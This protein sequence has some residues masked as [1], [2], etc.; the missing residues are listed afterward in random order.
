MS[1]ACLRNYYV[2][3]VASIYCAICG[4][5]RNKFVRGRRVA[6]RPSI[7][8]VRAPVFISDFGLD[9]RKLLKSKQLES[10]IALPSFI[11]ML[12]T[13]VIFVPMEGLFLTMYPLLSRGPVNMVLTCHKL[14]YHDINTIFFHLIYP[15]KYPSLVPS[16]LPSNPLVKLDSK[17]FPSYFPLLATSFHTSGTA[18]SLPTIPLRPPHPSIPSASRLASHSQHR[19]YWAC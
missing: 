12:C 2:S 6:F 4:E 5:L 10:F 8:S 9:K 17:F 19:H 13:Y 7:R 15:T 11:N 3:C 1:A 16:F 14:L 18:P